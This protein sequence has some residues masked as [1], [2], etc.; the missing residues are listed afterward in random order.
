[1]I[2]MSRVGPEG[3]MPPAPVGHL[4][5]VQ[6]GSFGVVHQLALA[7]FWRRIK[8]SNGYYSTLGKKC[9]GNDWLNAPVMQ[10]KRRTRGSACWIRHRMNKYDDPAI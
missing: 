5:P 2:P 3:S 6:Y 9:T 4:P 1:M 10:T 7:R 8:Q